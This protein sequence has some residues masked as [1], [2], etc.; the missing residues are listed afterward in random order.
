MSTFFNDPQTYYLY[1]YM[2]TYEYVCDIFEV[3]FVAG[4]KHNWRG[5]WKKT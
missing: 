2:Y 5:L 4:K 3:A 1:S